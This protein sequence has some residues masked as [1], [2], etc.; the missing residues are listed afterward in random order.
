MKIG[1]RKDIA[2]GS[3]RAVIV[4]HVAVYA[5]LTLALI[6]AGV[7]TSLAQSGLPVAPPPRAAKK[8]PPMPKKPQSVP[9]SAPVVLPDPPTPVQQVRDLGLSSCIDVVGKMA[10]ATLTS[11]YD[12]QSGW[13]REN[14][15]QHVFQSVAILN[16][17]DN[18]PPDGLAALVATPT[19]NGSC[20]GI[21]LQVFPLAGDCPSAQKALVAS[22]S[23]PTPILNA[24]VIFDR[25]GKR[26][27]LLPGF[28]RTCIAIAIDSTFGDSKAPN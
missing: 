6:G 20:D 7:S 22:G 13:N 10:Q 15:S 18:T 25:Q 5:L 8:L 24:Q 4:G 17:P 14:P 16:R 21:A 1:W 28:A 3:R 23:T 2:G 11:K 27:F 12:V 9:V 26:I 19:G